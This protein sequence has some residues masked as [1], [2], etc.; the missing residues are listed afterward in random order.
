MESQICLARLKQC[1]SGLQNRKM[2][3][4]PLKRPGLGLTL[5]A[6]TFIDCSHKTVTVGC[7]R[8]GPEHGKHHL[9][10]L[11]PTASPHSTRISTSWR[12]WRRQPAFINRGFVTPGLAIVFIFLCAVIAAV[13]V[14]GQPGAVV[15]IAAA[16][17]GAYMA[18]NIG[19]NDVANNVGPAVG[20]QAMTM[21]VALA[22][23]AIFESAG[24]LIA[25]GDVVATISKGIID[26]VAV[27]D[28]NVFIS[29][30]MAALVSAAMWIHL[31][32][33]IGA[34]VST[35]HS[36]VG[37]V[38]G[39]GIAAAGVDAVNWPT[40]GSNCSQL[41]DLAVPGRPDRRHLPRLHQDSH[42]LSGR[43]DFRRAALGAGADCG[44]DPVS[45]RP[46][47]RSRG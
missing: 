18:L 12:R 29:A 21:G 11:K 23:A 24:A 15:I 30:M 37:G 32:T 2:R 27:S 13:F 3:E 19:A 45:S 31:A 46:I 47:W 41:G 39:A 4:N 42:H 33:W 7:R 5:P 14:T 25:G 20:S 34:P 44:D 1:L 40:M 36:I 16:M 28:P 22:I 17:I 35:T 6:R 9:T 38:M 10:W 26:P 8:T 43:Q